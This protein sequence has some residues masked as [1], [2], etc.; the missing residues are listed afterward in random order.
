MLFLS[1]ADAKVR[2]IFG[3][4]KYFDDFFLI[5]FKKFYYPPV[6]L[7]KSAPCSTFVCYMYYAHVSILRKE[8][9]KTKYKIKKII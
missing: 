4:A 2:T 5:F 8:L 7:F 3:L 1:F 9:L 6:L